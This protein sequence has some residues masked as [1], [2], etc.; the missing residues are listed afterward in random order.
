MTPNI[1]FIE[2]EIITAVQGLLTGRVNEL[3]GTVQY[4]IPI[5]EIGNYCGSTAVVP[6]LAIVSCERSEKE[7]IIKLD[8]YSLTITFTLPEMPDSELHCFVYAWAVCKALEENSTLAGIVDRAV[9][10]GKKYIQPKKL[11]CSQEWELVL[12]LRITVEGV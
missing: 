6:V 5:V 4:A 8:V 1:E 9:I 3:L 2:Q 11:N 12:N 10:T 7:R